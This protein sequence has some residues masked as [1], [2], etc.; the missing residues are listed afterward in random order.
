[1]HDARHSF[2]TMLLEASGGNLCVVQK[3]LGH[4]RITTTTVY[5]DV[6]DEKTRESMKAMDQLARQTMRPSRNQQPGRMAL[7]TLDVAL[8][9]D[10]IPKI[11]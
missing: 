1:V 8:D 11:P 9:D 2:G 6:V 4:A 10:E 3:A 7:T 5:A